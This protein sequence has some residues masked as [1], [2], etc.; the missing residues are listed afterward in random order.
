MNISDLLAEGVNLMLLGMG[1]VFFI[2][3]LLV[4]VLKV[5]SSIIMKLE[6]ESEARS[7]HK[8]QQLTKIDE[9]IMEAIT[10]AVQRFR[11]K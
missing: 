7:L 5:S 6:V 1:M 3:S 2:L 8:A 9:N 4:V 11:S 10:V